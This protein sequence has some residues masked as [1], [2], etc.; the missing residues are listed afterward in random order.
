MSRMKAL[1]PAL[2]AL[3]A[4]VPATSAFAQ[5]EDGASRA[6]ITVMAPREEQVG[7]TSSGG[8]IRELTAQS[9]VYIDDLDLHTPAGR[10]ELKARIKAAAEDT[11]KW[12]DGIYPLDTPVDEPHSCV[13]RAVMGTQSQVDAVLANYSG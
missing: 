7:R 11:C 9:V 2:L 1:I 4:S 5:P 13:H 12:L 10:D 6:S 3:A 8:K